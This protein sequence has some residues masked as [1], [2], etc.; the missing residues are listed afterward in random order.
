ML[1]DAR[2]YLSD[3]LDRASF[4]RQYMMDKSLEDLSNERPIRSAVERELMVLG[5]AM[6][7]LH[8]HFPEMAEQIDSWKKIIHFR[9]ILVHGYDSLNMRVIWE[10]IQNKLDPLIKQIE[11]LLK[12]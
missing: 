7:Q 9:H 4:V 1:P 11:A 5:E 12:E 10:V 6:Y 8:R 2:K 3:M